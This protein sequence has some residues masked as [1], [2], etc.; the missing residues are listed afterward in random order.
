MGY[1]DGE[2]ALSLEEKPI[3]YNQ[4]FL[5]KIIIWS[6][7]RHKQQLFMTVIC[8]LQLLQSQTIGCKWQ[9]FF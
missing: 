3:I 1:R 4:L 6:Y 5:I 2:K 8:C 7:N 9:F